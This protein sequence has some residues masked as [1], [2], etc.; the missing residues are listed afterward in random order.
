MFL[1][2]ALYFVAGTT[3]AGSLIVAALTA[4]FTTTM[5]IVYAAVAGFIIAAPVTWIVARKLRG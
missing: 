3:L 5:P 1:V 4:G 2:L